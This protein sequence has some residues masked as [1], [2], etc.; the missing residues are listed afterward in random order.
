MASSTITSRKNWGPYPHYVPIIWLA[1]APGS[2]IKKAKRTKALRLNVKIDTTDEEKF[3]PKKSNDLFV[4]GFFLSFCQFGNFVIEKI[5]RQ[6]LFIKVWLVFLSLHWS[7][8]L[9]FFS[10][11]IRLLFFSIFKWRFFHFFT[12]VLFSETQDGI[13]SLRLVRKRN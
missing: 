9:V 5:N 2:S 7:F 6:H 11:C 8:H 4:H 1:N 10:F 12:I 3:E 13:H